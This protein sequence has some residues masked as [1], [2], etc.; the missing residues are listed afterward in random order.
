MGFL[1]IIAIVHTAPYVDSGCVCES[2]LHASQKRASGWVSCFFFFNPRALDV[3]TLAGLIYISYHPSPERAVISLAHTQKIFARF[4]LDGVF[5]VFIVFW[6]FYWCMTCMG[7]R[8]TSIM[9]RVLVLGIFI[10]TPK[11]TFIS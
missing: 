10:C 8:L 6:W 4:P 3:C 7:M 2:T 5:Y 1:P 9:R 11:L